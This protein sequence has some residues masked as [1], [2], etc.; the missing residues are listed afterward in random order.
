MGI[1]RIFDAEIDKLNPRTK[2][3]LIPK[4][5]LN[6]KHALVFTTICGSIFLISCLNISQKIFLLGS[7]TLIILGFYT[8]TKRIHWSCHYYLGICHGLVPLGV[9]IVINDYI[10]LEHSILA[11]G[12]LFW[13]ASFDIIYAIKDRSFDLKQKLCSIP[14]RFGNKNAYIFSV[15]STIIMTGCFIALGIFL[16]YSYKYYLGV[17][18]LLAIMTFNY[19]KSHLYPAN[20]SVTCN[21]IGSL[22]LLVFFLFENLNI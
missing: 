13:I 10:S 5:D 18:S 22:T 7:I 17:I 2:N 12:S 9:S 21:C 14:A 11:L 3:R 4:G 1:N 19:T 16:S 15:F 8:A 6:T 20:F